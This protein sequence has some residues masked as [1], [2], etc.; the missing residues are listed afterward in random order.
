MPC[1]RQ[2]AKAFAHGREKRTSPHHLFRGHRHRVNR[3]CA[4]QGGS[5]RA[6]V[7]M[8]WAQGKEPNNF[9]TPRG[10]GM[11]LIYS[12]TNMHTQGHLFTSTLC[13][14][15]H[16]TRAFCTQF[17]KIENRKERGKT[18]AGRE[19]MCIDNDR[20]RGRPLIHSRGSPTACACGV[21]STRTG[22]FHHDP[23]PPPHAPTAIKIHAS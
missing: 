1:S 17:Q 15:L 11:C 21:P 5:E 13:F 4:R 16:I 23:Q 8:P 2:E 14:F 19:G 20:E 3:Y 22:S 10:G 18:L 9:C 12:S 7:F 6:H